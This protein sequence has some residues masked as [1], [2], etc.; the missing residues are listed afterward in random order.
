MLRFD[1]EGTGASSGGGT[2]AELLSRWQVSVRTGL[3]EL[4]RRHEAAVAIP[5]ADAPT[6]RIWLSQ[7]I[8]TE[9]RR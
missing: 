9:I 8:T 1:Y 7:D 4:R 5:F 2:E 3:A 6:E